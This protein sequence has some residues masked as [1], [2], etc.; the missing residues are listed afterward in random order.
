MQID[1]YIKRRSLYLGASIEKKLK[2]Y[3]DTK[4]W[5]LLRDAHI[6]K[7]R[8]PSHTKLLELLCKARQSGLVV[9]PCYLPTFLELARQ[10]DPFTLQCTSELMDI[11]SGGVCLISPEERIIMEI[12]YFFRTES[13][14]A[15]SCYEPHLLAWT[16]ISYV[17]GVVLPYVNLL[18]NKTNRSLQIECFDS[19]WG[20]TLQDMLQTFGAHEFYDNIGRKRFNFA[21]KL[22][23]EKFEHEHELRSFSETILTEIGG[24]LDT[25]IPLLKEAAI[26]INLTETK[27]AA[28]DDELEGRCSERLMANSIYNFFRLGKIKNKLPTIKI[29][30]TLYAAIRWDKNRK[31]KDNDLLDIEHATGALPYCDVFLTEKSLCSLVTRKDI[32]FDRLYGCKVFSDPCLAV[33]AIEKQLDEIIRQGE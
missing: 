12:I 27:L 32:E 19:V 28:N 5:L 14:G 2:V 1:Q 13:D 23:S 4:Y 11:L 10:S 30:S 20:R 8:S 7:S 6:G 21:D 31:F 9:C 18:D 33:E 3:L 29:K 16:K 22:N 26:Q 25:I 24:I 15:E 17:L